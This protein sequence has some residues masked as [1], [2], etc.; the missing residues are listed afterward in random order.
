MKSLVEKKESPQKQ[1]KEEDFL[2]FGKKG[3][4]IDW[5]I[6]VEPAEY[7]KKFFN[8][9]GK[10]R[11]KIEDRNP[12]QLWLDREGK[13]EHLFLRGLLCGGDTKSADRSEKIIWR[14]S[15]PTA[16]ITSSSLSCSMGFWDRHLPAEKR[17][18][19]RDVF[20]SIWGQ[21]TFVSEMSCT[22]FSDGDFVAGRP[23]SDIFPDFAMIKYYDRKCC[24]SDFCLE[25]FPD[26]RSSVVLPTGQIA[27]GLTKK[28]GIRIWDS[29][30]TALKEILGKSTNIK[31]LRL[32]SASEL[33]ALSDKK[34]DVWDLEHK[35]VSHVFNASAF[36]SC[37]AVLPDKR[38][39]FSTPDGKIGIWNPDE[40]E[41]EMFE[42]SFE[43]ICFLEMLPDGNLI[44]GC[45]GG[46]VIKIWDLK[47]EKSRTLFELEKKLEM[48]TIHQSG[49]VLCSIGYPL[50]TRS[51][52]VHVKNAINVFDNLS[53]QQAAAL[54]FLML[55]EKDK[56]NLKKQKKEL[57]NELKAKLKK[58]P[59]MFKCLK[60]LGKKIFWMKNCLPGN[61]E[62]L[63]TFLLPENKKL[64]QVLKTLPLEKMK[65]IED[66]GYLEGLEEKLVS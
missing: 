65:I 24:E 20:G 28:G 38:L 62:F 47:S 35:K 57:K 64:I 39:A 58:W 36:G 14:P 4:F 7:F 11:G 37:L 3:S 6:K 15:R 56:R 25:K 8:E 29:E 49:E 48:L 21:R 1:V 19:K 52:V 18:K 51:F 63:D 16:L 30:L 26:F 32:L 54:K 66:R 41:S 55:V 13:A 22:S 43:E 33:V 5:A 23:P 46:R 27:L 53:A 12:Y 45:S 50:T 40:Q 42:E 61:E 2:E 17:K 34:I 59:S 31:V 60:P 10:G 9:M 44:F